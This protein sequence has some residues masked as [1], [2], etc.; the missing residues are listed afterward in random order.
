MNYKN[1]INLKGA[2]TINK[3]AIDKNLFVRFLEPGSYKG[4]FFI[5]DKSSGD[6]TFD[7]KL[8]QTMVKV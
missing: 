1:A 4:E 3:Y 7:D 8:G 2:Y 6:V 5:Y